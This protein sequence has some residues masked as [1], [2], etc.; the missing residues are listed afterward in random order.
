MSVH[1]LPVTTGTPSMAT[2][3]PAP[4]PRPSS[5]SVTIGA[6]AQCSGPGRS[7]TSS[8]GPRPGTAPCSEFAGGRR[9]VPPQ[10]ASRA[11]MV[12]ARSTAGIVRTQ[13]RD[14]DGARRFRAGFHEPD[15]D[16]RRERS[17]PNLSRTSTSSG[18]RCRRCPRGATGLATSRVALAGDL[19]RAGRGPAHLALR[20]ATA[21][22]FVQQR[23]TA[24][25]NGRKAATSPS[26]IAEVAPIRASA[27]ATTANSPDRSGAGDGACAG[28]ERHRQPMRSSRQ[29]P[30]GHAQR[31]PRPATGAPGAAHPVLHQVA[32]RALEHAG[33]DRQAIGKRAVAV[34]AAR[35][36][37]QVVGALGHGLGGPGVQASSRPS[38]AGSWSPRRRCGR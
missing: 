35:V 11:S 34:Q 26:S 3:S 38:T 22:A 5:S 18:R 10:A 9:S 4:W 19:D 30:A 14:R 21:S 8:A 29:P 28:R 24:R 2:R 13:L 1:V 37:G 12:S 33:A 20:P 7:G 23:G 16:A 27:A 25:S 6:S 17:T 15:D 32:T 36:P 31:G